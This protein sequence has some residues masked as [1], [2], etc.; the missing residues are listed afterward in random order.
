MLRVRDETAI[1]IL[2]VRDALRPPLRGC[3]AEIM[4]ISD[5]A[6]EPRGGG[7]D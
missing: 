4:V 7:R 2:R 5:I 1:V 3:S 6:T